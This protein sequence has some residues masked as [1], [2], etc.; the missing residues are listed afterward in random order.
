MALPLFSASATIRNVPGQYGA[1][2]AAINAC[3]M[4]DTVLVAPGVYQNI[5]FNGH[6]ITVASLF[7]ITGDYDYVLR[8]VIDGGGNGN[9]VT[10]NHGEGNAALLIGFT[11]QNSGTA[12]YNGG[13][14]CDSSSPSIVYSR[15]L[16]RTGGYGFLCNYANPLVTNTLIIGSS[17]AAVYC[18]NYSNPVFTNCVICGYG[19]YYDVSGGWY[20]S[21]NLVNCI[22]WGS[23]SR[24]F[25]GTVV[26]RYC[27]I[28]GGSP[29]E[30]NINL[31]PQFLDAG[32]LD[33]NICSQS[34]CIDAGEP[35]II[36]PDSTR[37]D[38]GIY[39]RTRPQC[40]PG[41]VWYISPTGSDSTG[42]GS[43]SNPFRTGRHGVTAAS[44]GDSV[45]FL[46]GTYHESLRI[47]GKYIVLASS[48]VSTG[49][50][51]DIHRTVLYGDSASSVVTAYLYDSTTTIEGLTIEHT[52]L[53]SGGVG[54]ECRDGNITILNNIIQNNFGSGLAISSPNGIVINNNIIRNTTTS[55]GA[56]IVAMGGSFLIQDNYIAFNKA[57]MAGGGGLYIGDA[58]VRVI[59]NV[60]EADTASN[61]SSGGAILGGDSQGQIINNIF[62]YNRAGDGGA[63]S[64]FGSDITLAANTIISNS[65]NTGGGIYLMYGEADSII[66][67]NIISYNSASN[68]GGGVACLSASVMLKNNTIRYNSAATGGGA[69]FDGGA[70]IYFNSILSNSATGNGGGVVLRNQQY[71]RVYNNII[72]GNTAANGGA[73]WTDHIFGSFHSN[74]FAVNSASVAGGGLFLS[75]NSN[76]SIGNSIL[77]ENTAANG[78]QLFLDPNSISSITFNDIQGGFPSHGNINLDPLFRNDSTGDYHL[79]S[80]ACGDT[81][82]SPCIDAG[83]PDYSDSLLACTW[84]LGTALSDMGAYG[85]GIFRPVSGQLINVPNDYSTI[86]DA[87]SAA[88]PYDTVL[89]APGVY[90]EVI[91]F[92]GK[93]ITV[94]SHYLTTGDSAFISS[95]VIQGESSSPTVS[96]ISFE[97]SA[98]AIFGFTIKSSSEYYHSYA[99]GIYCYHSSPVIAHNII[100]DHNAS[101]GGGIGCYY[102]NPYISCNL[103]SNSRSSF[104]GGIYGEMSSPV[105]KDNI[106]MGC[107]SQYG[108]GLHLY[109]SGPSII[110]GNIFKDDTASFGGAVFMGD[111]NCG[112][113]D[114]TVAVFHNNILYNNYAGQGGGMFFC[115]GV[116]GY[117]SN[118]VVYGNHAYYY[119]G[120][121]TCCSYNTHFTN[122]V[123]WGNSS[124]SLIE[125]DPR[126]DFTF[127]DIEGGQP[128]LGNINSDPLFRNPESGDFH[129][130]STACGDPA[131]SPCIDAGNLWMSDS[132]LN[133][134]WGLGESRS[135][136]GAY[137]G[138]IISQV[139]VDDPPGELPQNL[140]LSQNHPNPF[141]PNTTISYNLPKTSHVSLEIYD[142]LGRKVTTLINEEQSAGP[143]QA[144][145]NA[146]DVASGLYFYRLQ[147][148]EHS[149]TRKMLLL[150]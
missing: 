55:I 139:G 115:C 145:W 87:I 34:P 63:I 94:G 96:F 51:L 32:S 107:Y 134:L 133:C 81:A 19:G 77:W 52:A 117:Y 25:D 111:Y 71:Y 47:I 61:N 89:V 79:S 120:I 135:D 38:I 127:C 100:K 75:N 29:G 27:D 131:N 50:T 59:G 35:N 143:H 119:G 3:V 16:A 84:G 24:E 46:N 142:I 17:E 130:M 104:G 41:E 56:G 93:S 28:R 65:A 147:A 2:Q 31:D 137:G 1:I 98:A 101:E 86:Q 22:C 136:M 5:N 69:Y 53:G 83:S 129:L 39:F 26:S 113:G 30:G 99:G 37:S 74:V 132:T 118:N 141:N 124:D 20:G 9:P 68:M 8:T 112:S 144:V 42:D 11:L 18:R 108:G 146:N 13:I 85:S 114:S 72:T 57:S 44:S 102:A 76:M 45:I 110:S 95:T 64:L 15:I 123:F 49:D 36:D 126:F 21:P 12:Y 4:G 122:C 6:M 92:L 121:T 128:G 90:H 149:E 91:N 23:V 80:L 48:F 88:D 150:R 54:I 66:E 138:G 14:C 116:K 109:G 70:N 125:V 97:N 33:Y 73:V 62:R 105:V 78:P 60:F 106:I 67:N 43:I 103:I 82:D 148:G 10:F 58:N 40:T 140:S 7:L